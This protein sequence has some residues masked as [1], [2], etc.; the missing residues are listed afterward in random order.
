MIRRTAL[1]AAATFI[2]FAVALVSAPAVAES[3]REVAHPDQSIQSSSQ[4]ARA[5]RPLPLPL[6][7]RIARIFQSDH[8]AVASLNMEKTVRNEFEEAAQLLG[9]NAAPFRTY[10]ES[11]VYDEQRDAVVALILLKYRYSMT[12]LIEQEFAGVVHPGPVGQVYRADLIRRVGERQGTYDE[13]LVH[14]LAWL[15]IIQRLDVAADREISLNFLI[16]ITPAVA[17]HFY[18]SKDFGVSTGGHP[19]LIPTDD[20]TDVQLDSR[21]I[22]V[23]DFVERYSSHVRRRLEQYLEGVG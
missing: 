17:Q 23:G 7:V 10:E 13:E 20:M 15:R 18:N 2:P 5:E 12:K 1:T 14:E 6:H 8:T 19:L 11:P 3:Q 4:A 9:V 22:F 21:E 16:N